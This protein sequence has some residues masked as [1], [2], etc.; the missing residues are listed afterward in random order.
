[1]KISI[2]DRFGVLVAFINNFTN[3]GWDGS[4]NGKKLKANNFWFKAEIID[5]NDNPVSMQIKVEGKLKD[6]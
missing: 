1:M 2:F 4:Y 3:P 5:I 6:E